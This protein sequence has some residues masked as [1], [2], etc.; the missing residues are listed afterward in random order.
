[1]EAVEAYDENTRGSHKAP[2]NLTGVGECVRR[3]PAT[4]LS[5]APR[6]RAYDANLLS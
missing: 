1:M 5:G 3:E 2:L 4:S 6:T